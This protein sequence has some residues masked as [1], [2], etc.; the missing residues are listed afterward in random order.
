M[1]T[2]PI[3]DTSILDQ[4]RAIDPGFIKELVATFLEDAPKRLQALGTA[5][6][7]RQCDAIWREAHG[8]KGSALGIGAA[9]MASVCQA[10]E[11]AAA[12][13]ALDQVVAYHAGLEEE[14]RTA[15]RALQD[16]V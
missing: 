1:T 9:R 2:T 3:L 14:L 15:A 6:A 12:A 11:T 13:G 10:I 5:V 7:G 16:I 4:L 8:L